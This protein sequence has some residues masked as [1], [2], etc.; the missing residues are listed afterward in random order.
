RFEVL[1]EELGRRLPEWEWQPPLGG[2]SIWVRLPRGN[3]E[4]FGAI[5]RRHGVAILPGSVFSP[6]NGHGDHIR[7]PFC[8]EPAEIRDGLARLARAWAEYVPSPGGGPRAERPLHVV[9]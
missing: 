7:L 6:T 2:L 9:V 8:L 4:E 5:A 3:A 1:A